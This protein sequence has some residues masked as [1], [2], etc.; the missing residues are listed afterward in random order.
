M[1]RKAKR[2]KIVLDLQIEAM[3]VTATSKA[4]PL[5][6]ELVGYFEEFENFKDEQARQTY[7]K[8]K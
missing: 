8:D 7:Y 5:P 4:L 6:P 2:K 3:K 1:A